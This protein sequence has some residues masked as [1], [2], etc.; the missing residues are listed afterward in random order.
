MVRKNYSVYWLCILPAFLLYA[1]AIIVPLLFGTLPFSFLDWNLMTGKKVFTGIQNYLSMFSDAKFFSIFLFTLKIGIINIVLCNVLAF[2]LAYFLSQKIFAKN[3]SR[4]LFFI[5]NIISAVLVAFVWYVVFAWILPSFGEAIHFQ[6]LQDVSWFGEPSKAT[7]TIIVVSVWQGIGFALLIY[8]AGFQTIPVELIEAGKIDG[9]TGVKS[10]LKI[11]LPLLMS[12]ITIN[13]FVSISAA[14]KAFDIPF[15]LTSGGPY[16]TTQTVALNIYRE[17][18]I[19]YRMGMGSAKA[20]FLF[21][22]VAIITI[23]QLKVTRDREVE[24]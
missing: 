20:A 21:L 13:L 4:S 6:W 7:F 14:F 23:I 16:G 19:R 1:F 18:F 22:V 2:I 24:Y 8:I 10:V 17:A 15:A 3:L 12:T 9:C 11:Q 5:P